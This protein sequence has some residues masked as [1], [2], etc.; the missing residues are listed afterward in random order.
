M[1]RKAAKRITAYILWHP[2]HGYENVLSFVR[3]EAFVS[4]LD[5]S[6]GV[7]VIRFELRPARKAKAKKAKRR[8]RAGGSR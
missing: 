2:E 8:S 6:E 1:R 4:D 5:K 7:E 3:G